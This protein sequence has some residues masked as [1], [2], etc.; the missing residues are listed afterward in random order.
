MRYDF[1]IIWA[2]G[3]KHIPEILKIINREYNFKIIYETEYTFDNMEIFINNIYGC[4][5]VPISHLTAKNKYLL[6]TEKRVYFILTENKEPDEHMVGEGDFRHTQCKKVTALKNL[7][8]DLYNP[9]PNEHVIHSSDY[10][11]QVSCVL[12]LLGLPWLEDFKKFS[13]QIDIVNLLS[14]I[15]CKYAVIR[16]PEYFPNYFSGSD[17]D[18]LC[19]DI[20]KASEYILSKRGFTNFSAYKAGD[21]IQIDFYNQAKLDLKIDLAPMVNNEKFT[22]SVLENTELKHGVMMPTL[23][24]DLAV[25]YWEG[26][27]KGKPKHIL[28][29]EKFPEVNYKK[30]LE[31]AS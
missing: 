5:S 16:A 30:I 27:K 17:I 7:I 28:Y 2:N 14:D 13:N 25:R 15:P 8:R 22:K 3:L 19:E 4:D 10:Q 29:C 12:T 24:Y 1:F 26:I 9:F 21:H 11:S 20:E 6:R 31:D 23:E 18:I